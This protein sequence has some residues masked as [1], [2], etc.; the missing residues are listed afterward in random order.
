MAYFMVNTK[1]NFQNIYLGY[2]DKHVCK[3]II[4]TPLTFERNRQIKSLSIFMSNFQDM[5]YFG[6][7]MCCHKV[8]HWP[9]LLITT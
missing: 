2:F 1:C 5:N 6:F 7:N 9:T 8:T 4:F 3:C